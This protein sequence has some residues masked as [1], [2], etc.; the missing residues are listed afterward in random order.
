MKGRK[1]EGGLGDVRKEHFPTRVGSE[2]QGGQG[3]A[4][5]LRLPLCNEPRQR[6]QNTYGYFRMSLQI[7]EKYDF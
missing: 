6:L 2:V 1:G 7:F 5:C 4:G 3:G